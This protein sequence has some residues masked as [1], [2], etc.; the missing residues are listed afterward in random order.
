MV[1]SPPVLFQLL[2]M[3]SEI[4]KLWLAALRGQ[5]PKKYKQGAGGLRNLSDEYCCLG[6]L[7][8]V[9][10]P[11]GWARVE[12]WPDWPNWLHRDAHG[13]LSEEVYKKAGLLVPNP[14]VRIN[15]LVE[16][17]AYHNDAGN[18]FEVIAKAIE[19]QL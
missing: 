4:K 2:K 19:E 12:S 15:G 11:E 6:V 9:V 17:L 1:Q 18:S 13:V 14:Y 7:C 16:T 3:N 5:G 10:D 8:D